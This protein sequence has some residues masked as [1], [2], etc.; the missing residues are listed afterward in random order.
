MNAETYQ[1]SDNVD[2]LAAWERDGTAIPLTDREAKEM[3]GM[4]RAERRQYARR[5]GLFSRRTQRTNGGP[6]R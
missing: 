1:I 3:A 5:H 4:N 2:L 6:E